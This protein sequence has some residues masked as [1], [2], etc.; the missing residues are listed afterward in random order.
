MHLRD[1]FSRG[2]RNVGI[3]CGPSNICVIDVDGQDTFNALVRELGPLPDTVSA[4]TGGGGHHYV[5]RRPPGDLV[6]KLGP[7]VDLLHGP[8]QF[9]IE[10]SL[11]ASG[12]AYRWK[13]GRAPDDHPIAE[14]PASWIRK[15]TRA[16]PITVPA[17]PTFTTDV[18]TRRARA[19][20]AKLPPAVSGQGGH[21]TTF[22]A[23]AAV[24]IGFDL[25]GDTTAS[26][27]AGEYNGRC[28]PPWSARE[29]K[30]KIDSVSRT[31]KR[32]RGYLLTDR[33]TIGVAPVA[34][35]LV[36]AAPSQLD[37]DWSSRLLVKR[38]RS[39]KRAYH[40]V[41]VFVRHHPD[42]R[43]RW[44]LDR[45]TD[46]PHFDGQSVTPAF[47]NELRAA[48]DVRLGFTPS[49]AD[50]EAAI[51]AAASDRPFHPVLAYLRSVD[52]DGQPRLASMAR[53]Y[54]GS[55][56][57]VH[58]DMIR[59]FMIGAAAR[60]LSP[61]CKHD[62]ALML[63]GDQGIRKSSFFATLGGQWHADSFVDLSNKDGMIQIHSA[64]IYELAE[65]E[66]VVM[67]RAES[68]LKAWMTSAYDTYRAPYQ[69]TV[70]RRARS[71][72]ICGTTNRA[73]FLTDETGSRRFWIV[74]VRQRIPVELLAELRDQLWAE[75]VNAYE[76][77]EPWWLDQDSDRARESANVDF[78]EDDSWME[79][80]RQFLSVPMTVMQ[81]T[82]VYEV[83]TDALK[84]DAARQDRWAQMRAARCLVRCGWKRVKAGG[85]GNREYR[86]F[87]GGDAT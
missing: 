33:R 66:N 45:M 25:D 9:L 21:T 61:G 23:V 85:R 77:G 3:A 51:V 10:P 58:A 64:W 24:M 80:I 31:C 1:W 29:I 5:F 59:K 2:D 12:N 70:S 28:D 55:D 16:A 73:Q 27:I 17:A 34:A 83:L 38:D 40:N 72:V 84:L 74:P 57:E 11:H 32:E 14:L 8:R 56:D 65:L 36:P 50:V 87:R 18:R 47:V 52:W 37:L 35:P 78:A 6:S 62:T 82:T 43:N 30:H 54:L 67:G 76:A 4:D 46:T 53:D 71:V 39:V 26:L 69:R 63:V 86:Y 7:G 13:A 15:A 20:L 75:A 42:Y 49:V 48:S 44:S 22:N 19:Y 68:R 60:M 79:P 41:A 81:S